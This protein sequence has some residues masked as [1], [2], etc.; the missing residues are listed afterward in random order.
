MNRY[1]LLLLATIVAAVLRAVAQATDIEESPA[2][3][4]QRERAFRLE[5]IDRLVEQNEAILSKPAPASIKR[6]R[7]I[8]F[9]DYQRRL[10]DF[11]WL[12]E[13]VRDLTKMSQSVGADCDKQT[14][15]AVATAKYQ[16]SQCGARLLNRQRVLIW[17]DGEN[18]V[19][20]AQEQLN[21]RRMT[22]PSGKRYSSSQHDH[23]TR[24]A[25]NDFLRGKS[26][27][28]YGYDAF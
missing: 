13:D 8:I 24:H 1:S 10:L 28:F 21:R 23:G 4:E 7:A 3:P 2:T 11:Q 25:L 20:R 16:L 5:E 12:K 19:K 17:L 26:S 22:R 9:A 27:T 15:D 14:Q 18:A 6:D